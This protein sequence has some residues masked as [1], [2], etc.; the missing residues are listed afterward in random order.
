MEGRR[1]KSPGDQSVAAAEPV[2]F[3]VYYADGV[4]IDR[5]AADAAQ[6]RR[7]SHAPHRGPILKIKRIRESSQ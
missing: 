2:R 6:A 4:V 1:K 5:L 3:R 7:L